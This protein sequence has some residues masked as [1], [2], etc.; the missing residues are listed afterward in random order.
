MPPGGR[1]GRLHPR[2][3]DRLEDL[4]RNGAVQR[5]DLDERA[6]DSLAQLPPTE[7]IESIDRLEQSVAG[8]RVRNPAAYLAG[9]LR[10]L[11]RD[12][13]PPHSP[14]RGDRRDDRPDDRR[15]PASRLT[16]GAEA[17][18]REV[19]VLSGPGA[20]DDRSIAGLARLSPEMQYLVADT[21]S[22]RRLDGIRSMSAYF[23]SHLSSVDRDVA[24]GRLVPPTPAQLDAIEERLPP[25]GR[26]GEGWGGGGGGAAPAALDPTP[27][28]PVVPA[29]LKHHGL[30]QLEWG[31]RVDEFHS[32]SPLAKYVHPAAALKLQ[33]LW[34]AGNR[35]VSVL[36][37][38]SFQCLA[39]LDAQAGVATV[40]ETGEALRTLPPDDLV[41][42]NAVFAS[43]AARHPRAAGGAG[44]GGA[45]SGGAG[46]VGA[47]PQGTGPQGSAATQPP[48]SAQPAGP[49]AP[50]HA[51]QQ[52]APYPAPGYQAPQTGPGPVAGGYAGGASQGYGGATAAPR[53]APGM[54][55]P[56][57]QAPAPSQQ[58][59][60]YVPQPAY[61]AQ[62]PPAA[63]GQAA[64]YAAGPGPV[65]YGSGAGAAP[66]GTGP[67]AAPYALGAGAAPY[68]SGAGAASYGSGPGAAPYA[69]GLGTTAP[70]AAAPGAAAPYASAPGPTYSTGA[71]ARLPPSLQAQLAALVAKSGGFLRVDH[72]NDGLVD[73]LLDMGEASA[74]GVLS[75]LGMRDLSMVRNMPG[76]IYGALRQPPTDAPPTGAPSRGLEAGGRGG[77]V[78]YR[79]Y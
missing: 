31:V 49:G 20:L 9:V 58:A 13:G 68:A 70:Y 71:V 29:G 28:A 40:V 8:G 50:Y 17:K 55:L 3:L 42:A 56:A 62:Q 69:A 7:A 6:L 65:P 75:R 59:G 74:A 53:P 38:A 32:L 48:R 52:L 5:R 54:A 15:D 33:Q 11:P 21:F 78:R 10:R 43:I 1:P 27:R 24:T 19:G 67:A 63:A 2:V 47:G 46:P 73:M 76:Y 26:P 35:L 64:A 60:G 44:T 18:L 36:N 72:F 41:A 25:R 14:G 16:P 61:G 34:D 30:E 4:Y 45:G 22:T 77:G 37:D 51:Q 79:P 57:G 12:S 66:Y 39:Q 23:A